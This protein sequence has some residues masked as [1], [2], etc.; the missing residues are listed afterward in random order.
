ME[1]KNKIQIRIKEK[2]D[3]KMIE[4]YMDSHHLTNVSAF[5]YEMIQLGIKTKLEGEEKTRQ[6]EECESIRIRSLE[7]KI[8]GLSKKVDFLG[9]S[10]ERADNL[11]ANVGIE[12]EKGNQRISYVIRNQEKGNPEGEKLLSSIHNIL[13]E[14]SSY[15]MKKAIDSGEFDGLPERFKKE[16]PLR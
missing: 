9:S 13:R 14:N 8:E 4:D 7:E 16:E 10:L 2:P 6:Q 5:L 12:V 15:R 3:V 1:L 11:I